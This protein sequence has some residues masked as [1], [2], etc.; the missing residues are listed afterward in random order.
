MLFSIE[1]SI[2]IAYVTSP[3]FMYI[4]YNLPSSRL[5]H[6]GFEHQGALLANKTSFV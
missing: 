1:I 3:S 4:V 6:L 5:T 2:C